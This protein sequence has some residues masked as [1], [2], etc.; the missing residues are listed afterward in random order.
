M[1]WENNQSPWGKSRRPPEVD[2][3]LEKIQARFRGLLGN[4]QF[5]VFWIVLA[6]LLLLWLATGIYQV[7]PEEKGVVQR[8]GKYHR[9]VDPGLQ[10]KWPT[11]I[12]KVTKVSVQ[13]IYQEEFGFRTLRAGARSEY[14]PEKPYE[15]EALMLTGDLNCVLVPWVVRYRIHEPKDFLFNVRNVLRTLRDL[16][17]ATMRLVVGDHSLDEVLTKREEISFLAQSALQKALD[18]AQSGVSVNTI[19]LGRTNV[20]APVQPSFNEVNSS[21]QEKEKLIYEAQGAYNKVVPEA[22]GQAQKRIQEAEG[23]AVDRVK[24]AQGDASRFLAL[25]TE[26]SKAKEVT[27]QRL[28]LEA[29]QEVLVLL[30][31]KYVIDD[32]QRGLLPLLNLGDKGGQP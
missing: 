20:P 13:R 24:R 9:T 27:R 18:M 10:W 3:V 8:F 2:E 16:S 14:S 11:G 5:P 21:I 19:E 1:S 6:A 30:G 4:R 31:K 17:E 12:E 29:M 7:N 15:T 28:Y 32:K 26:Y 23:Y 22:R 25:Y